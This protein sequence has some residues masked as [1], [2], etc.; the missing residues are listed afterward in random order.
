MNGN[1]EK[2]KVIAEVAEK[3]FHRYGYAKTSLEDIAREAKLGKG[4][5]YYYFNSKEDI[6]FEVVREHTD[7]FYS[8]L[9][10]EIGKCDSFADKFTAAL[11]L[12]IKLMYEHAPILLEAIKSL[13]PDYMHK[14]DSYR[15]DNK[16]KMID[17]LQGVIDF[18]ISQELLTPNIPVDKIIHIIFDW[19]L[20][21]DS[22]IFIKFPEEFLHKAEKDFENIVQ[23]ILYGIIKRG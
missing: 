5:I 11:K 10:Y 7:K 18:G 17:I 16:R 15:Q 8:K 12:P 13:P 21:G 22:N 9:N 20:L 6:F 23:I 1:P 4:T 3:L 14:L 2:K 19:I